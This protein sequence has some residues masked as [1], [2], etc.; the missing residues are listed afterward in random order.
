MYPDICICICICICVRIR[1]EFPSFY[2]DAV[3]T[4]LGINLYLFREHNNPKVK[5]QKQQ[6][7]TGIHESKKKHKNERIRRR[8]YLT[9]FV[10]VSVHWK[11]RLRSTK[12]MDKQW[13]KNSKR[14]WRSSIRYRGHIVS[15][16]SIWDI[17]DGAKCSQCVRVSR[18]RIWL[19]LHCSCCRLHHRCISNELPRPSW[20]EQI[21][22]RE[23]KIVSPQKQMQIYLDTDTFAHT[24]AVCNLL[25]FVWRIH[26][27]M[28]KNRC[29]Q[30][31]KS[32][33]YKCIYYLS[34]P[35]PRRISHILWP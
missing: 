2:A 18:R 13:A 30:V 28:F 4:S 12:D 33:R 1:L 35:L 27:C 32:V 26:W 24:I 22:Q 7:A 11:Q 9:V 29:R 20:P 3:H 15:H 21:G 14:W 10:C 17:R 16:P 5:N 23:W 19:W 25:A 31:P 8:L 34:V 6:R